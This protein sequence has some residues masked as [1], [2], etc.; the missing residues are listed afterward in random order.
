MWCLLI[1][2]EH[3]DTLIEMRGRRVG[4]NTGN[5]SRRDKVS[6]KMKNRTM[7]NFV[8]SRKLSLIISYAFATAYLLLLQQL[9]YC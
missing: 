2:K 1:G 8:I 4:R 7:S 3:V 5:M 6:A 9:I